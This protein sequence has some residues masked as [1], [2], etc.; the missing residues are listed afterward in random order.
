MTDAL[1]LNRYLY[2][3]NDPVNFIDPSGMATQTRGQIARSAQTTSST[4]SKAASAA[5]SAAK[6]SSSPVTTMYANKA[7]SAAA[8]AQALAKQA[9]TTYNA[10]TAKKAAAAAAQAQMYSN[11]AVN[12]VGN[13]GVKKA[14]D[15][16]NSQRE[17][18]LYGGGS[19]IYS[20]TYNPT[21]LPPIAGYGLTGNPQVD[22]MNGYN[23]GLG[24]KARA[25]CESAI[26]Y[27]IKVVVSS[28]AAKDPVKTTIGYY[29]AKEALALVGKTYLDS[30][31]YDLSKE[32]Y[33]NA[34]YGNGQGLSD[35]ALQLATEK[36]KDSRGFINQIKT[37]LLN[38]QMVSNYEFNTENDLNVD[39]DLYY[40]LQ[41]VNYTI[42]D[43]GGGQYK[44]N[45]SDTYD[46]DHI[47]TGF[48][49]V[50][51]GNAANDLGWVMTQVGMMQEYEF[52]TSFIVDM[53]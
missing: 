28:L 16:G 23:Q 5:R 40:S 4:A 14:T 18:Q 36:L 19:S 37:E 13:Y 33:L 38:N 9:K 39:P 6:T 8:Q 21:N 11:L 34:I 24:D 41:H 26:G 32:M 47:R 44:V 12:S 25:R 20:S 48:E 46:F 31:G 53:S 17:A 49:G 27:E 22:V 10:D 29:T 52:E 43:I 3:Q 15:G 7:A 42:E 1:S 30:K 2:C 51:L 35:S 45:V 50:S